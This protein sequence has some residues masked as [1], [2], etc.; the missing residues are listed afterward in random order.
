MILLRYFLHDRDFPSFGQLG[1]SGY[2]IADPTGAVLCPKTPAWLQHRDAALAW[3]RRTLRSLALQP[4]P[5]VAPATA[6]RQAALVCQGPGCAE[7]AEASTAGSDAEMELGGGQSDSSGRSDLRDCGG[8]SDAGSD[9]EVEGG[10]GS[11]DGSDLGSDDSDDLD[12]R[13]RGG[14]A[15]GGG[16]A[17]APAV[18]F[19][20]PEALHAEPVDREHRICARRLNALARRRDA[21]ALARAVAALASHFA[22]EERL[23]LAGAGAGRA[24][25]AHAADHAAIL[26]LARAELRRCRGPPG[27]PRQALA[28]GQEFL[29]GLAERFAFHTREYDA[30]CAAALRAAAAAE[31]PSAGAGGGD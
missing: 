20:V 15:A 31:P 23:L 8:R 28:V 5:A 11:G 7:P 10:D 6:P 27:G 18:R 12:A 19:E 16:G 2:I 1:C 4:G 26:A 13:A 14:G 25:D 9:D 21:P 22:H 17:G 29:A 30:R 3:M 24:V